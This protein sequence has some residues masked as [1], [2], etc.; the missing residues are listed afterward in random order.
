MEKRVVTFGTFDLLH[1]G[2]VRMLER[3]KALGTYLAVGVSTNTLNIL[4]KNRAPVYGHDDRME[5]IK[6]LRCVDHVFSEESLEKK[7]EYCKGFDIFVIGDDWKGKFDFL[8]EDGLEVKYL[9]RTPS[10][11]TTEILSLIREGGNLF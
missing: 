6:S 5:I 3:C 7:A 10:I 1:V 8:E 4:K 11:S 9:E 2:H